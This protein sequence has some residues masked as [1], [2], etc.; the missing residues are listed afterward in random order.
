MSP[1]CSVLTQ[2]LT[3][4]M[5]QLW[6]LVHVIASMTQGVIFPVCPINDKCPSPKSLWKSLHGT[7]MCSTGVVA[8]EES[9]IGPNTSR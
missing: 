5:L 7:P 6:E 9:P 3:A 1:I 2:L 8:N 4:Y